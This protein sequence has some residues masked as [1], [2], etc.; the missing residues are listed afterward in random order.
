MRTLFIALGVAAALGLAAL[1]TRMPPSIAAEMG[2]MHDMGKMHDMMGGM[3][4]MEGGTP[5]MMGDMG[6]P[7]G[8]DGPASLAYQGANNKMHAAMA[9]TYSGETDIDFAR[10][11][12]PHHRG[13]IDMAKIV[14]AFGSDPEIRQLAEG[15]IKAQES[16][17]ALMQEWLKKKGQ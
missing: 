13:A 3:S 7:K 15:I 9:I 5:G 16:E 2:G 4:G 14:L 10:S 11:M 6:Q 17:I 8:D 12:I 1:A